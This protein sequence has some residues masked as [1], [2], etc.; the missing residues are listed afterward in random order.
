MI[1]KYRIKENPEAKDTE[2]INDDEDQEVEC[3]HT[4]HYDQQS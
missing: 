3:H 2:D 4:D 1:I